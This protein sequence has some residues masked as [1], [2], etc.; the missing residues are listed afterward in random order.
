MDGPKNDILLFERI[1]A[2][3]G[4]VFGFVY[5]SYFEMLCRFACGM[6]ND[7]CVAEDI[8]NDSFLELWDRRRQ[9]EIKNSLKAYL[10]IMV[11][12]K[13]LNHIKRKK[14]EKSVYA[15]PMFSS[16]YQDEITG[17]LEKLIQM[18]ALELHLKNAIE[19][20]PPQ[21]RQIFK[22]SR[23]NELSY[24]EIADQMNLSVFTVKTQIARALKSLRHEFEGVKLVLLSLFSKK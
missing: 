11:R 13:A 1:K 17:Q 5:F 20:L 12:N 14:I 10:L 23:F 16:S 21:C 22:L 4:K 19:Q 9:I 8:V 15:D 18:E 6:V 2:D 3:D 7:Q 24:Q